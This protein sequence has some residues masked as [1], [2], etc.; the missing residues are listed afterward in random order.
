MKTLVLSNRRLCAPLAHACAHD[1]EDAIVDALDADIL[2]PWEERSHLA[3]RYDLLVVCAVSFTEMLDLI[4]RGQAMGG[5]PP[6]GR[7]VGYLFGA[8]GKL[9]RKGRIPI[10]RLF[11]DWR[12][13]YRFLD[14]L[15]LGIPYDAEQISRD[16]GLPTSYLPMAANVL[17]AN[18]KPFGDRKDRPLAIN[19][20][21][22]QHDGIMD[23]ICDRLNRAGSTELVYRTNLVDP[24][25]ALDLP[26]YRAMFWQLL[27]M[28]RVSMAF[29]HFVANPRGSAQH[30]YVG[31]RWFEALAAGTVIAG[32]G[33]ATDEAK[34]L[35]DWPD[36]MVDVSLDPE[37]A[38]GEL[39]ALIADDDRLRQASQRNLAEMNARHD[40]RHRLD[41]ILREEGLDRPEKLAERLSTLTERS[42]QIRSGLV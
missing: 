36:A 1:F 16:L 32:R 7:K 3:P 33:P 8:Y 35:L 42:A 17:G 19:A 24:G 15:Y 31:P 34:A 28:S 2:V 27:R 14:R 38:A 26:R 6:I 5:L 10:R 25:D 21:G 40:W 9:V 29:D 13:E 20:F 11:K 30:S 39:E 18:A 37:A 12:K 22:R 23:A 4:R 41:S